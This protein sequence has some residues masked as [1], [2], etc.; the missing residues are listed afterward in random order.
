MLWDKEQ[1]VMQTIL[2]L[3]KRRTLI[4]CSQGPSA[5]LSY[6]ANKFE[7]S[8]G[9]LFSLL[10]RL[11]HS[12]KIPSTAWNQASLLCWLSMSTDQA[13]LTPYCCC[14]CCCFS[15]V[16]VEHVNRSLSDALLLLHFGAD[17]QPTRCKVQ[18]VA[19]GFWRGVACWR[20]LPLSDALII[21]CC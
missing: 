12:L 13:G 17:L 15:S 11:T 16:P 6:S 10:L 20:A 9:H 5:C 19:D 14:C 21:A 7:Y 8:Q 3:L 2:L 18:V 1:N 4:L